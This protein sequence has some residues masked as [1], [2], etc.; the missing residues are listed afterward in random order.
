MVVTSQIGIRTTE[1]AATKGEGATIDLS[2]VIVTHNSHRGLEACLDGLK[3]ASEG[4]AAEIIVVDNRS[5][6]WGAI[7]SRISAPFPGA[8]LVR[9]DKNHGFATAV[10]R[11][12][13]EATGTHI[14]LLNPDVVLQRETIR[15]L[16]AA[17]KKH[18]DSAVA[19]PRLTFPDGRFQPSCRQFPSPANI[20]FSRG[21]VFGGLFT[22]WFYT[23][24]D[25][26]VTTPVPAAAGAVM[27]IDRTYFQR[28]GGF[29]ERFFLYPEDMDFCL[30]VFRDGRNV[31][32]VPQAQA[33][34]AWGTGSATGSFRRAWLHHI[35][36]WQ[37][38]AKHGPAFFAYSLLPLLLA[39]NFLATLLLIPFGFRNAR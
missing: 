5:H 10:N 4:F 27:L 18:P 2:V 29:D 22:R 21:S 25:Y 12:V 32:F 17:L 6:D 19:V 36:I 9:L 30:R 20:L 11:G 38:F 28:L 26:P 13:E 8:R 24:P 14:L 35:S 1:V 33:V 23:L 15:V 37:Y 7:Q 39:V 16:M 34:H 31:I 3:H